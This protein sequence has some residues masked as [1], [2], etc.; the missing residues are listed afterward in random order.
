MTHTMPMWLRWLFLHVLPP[1]LWMQPSGNG[2][3]RTKE[4]NFVEEHVALEGSL[5]SLAKTF[6]HQRK[7]VIKVRKISNRIF[8]D[9]CFVSGTKN[10]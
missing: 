7:Y 8:F 1:M 10:E 2:H 4:K 6:F 9:L 5:F 3:Q